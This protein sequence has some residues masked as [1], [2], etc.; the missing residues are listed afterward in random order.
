MGHVERLMSMRPRYL[1]LVLVALGVAASIAWRL[2]AKPEAVKAQDRIVILIG[3]DGFRADYLKKFQPPVLS[4]LAKEGVTAEKMIPAFPTLTFPNLYTLATGLRPENHGIIGN[5]FYDPEFDARFALGSP[6]VIEGRWWGGEPVWLTAERQGV[7]AACMFWPGSE[8]EIGGKRPTDWRLYDGKVTAPERVN[9]VLEWLARPAESRPRMITLYFHEADSAA[10]KFGI[11]APAT[12]E[13][14]KE[15]DAA[16]AQL[17]IGI[18]RLKLQDKVNLIC[19]S[20]HGMAA[21]SPDCTIPLSE[22]FTAAEV[23]TDYVGAVAGLRPLSISAADVVAR[24][25]NKGGPFQV[26]LREEMPE[27]LHFR[28]NRRISPVVMVAD[29]G[30]SIVQAPMLTEGSRKTFLQ[31]THGFD[32]DLPSMAAAFI[33][34]GPAYRKEQTLLPFSNVEVYDLICATLGLVPASNDGTGSLAPQVLR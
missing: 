21:V 33:A 31:A 24:L 32:P 4:R 13:A 29:E 26:Y 34:W 2:W 20:D 28:M 3:L 16:L 18:D 30:W 27:R 19:V 7:K 25:K 23:D 22:F 9:T 14:V 11:E 1:L 8:A 12:A 17:L 15:I 6:S 10:H 5:K